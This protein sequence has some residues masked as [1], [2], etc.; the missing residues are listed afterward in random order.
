MG[1]SM[2]KREI[3][4][5]LKKAAS[6]FPITLLTG[7][8]QS[9]KTTLLKTLFPDHK[10][11]NLETPSTLQ[12]LQDDPKGFLET[13]P[14]EFIL[15]EAQKFPGFFSYLQ[16]HVDQQ[17]KAKHIL[18][19]GSQ[20]FLLSEQI[21]QTLAGRVAIL[22]LL[23]L[24][25]QELLSGKSKFKKFS[26]WD[27]LYNG[28]YPRP[29]Q[30]KLDH[31]LWYNSYIRTYLERDIRSLIGLKDFNKFQLFLKLCA[32][33]HG[34][35][36]NMNALANDCGVSQPTVN[37]WL[38]IL[39]TTYIVY[40]LPPYYRNFNKRIIKSPK[41]YFY[42]SALVCQLLGIESAEQLQ[43][44]SGRGAIFEGYVISEI[45]K[46]YFNRGLTAPVFFWRDQQGDEVD[47]IVE[48][49]EK[50]TAYEV[51]SSSTY[52]SD[53]TKN[54]DKIDKVSHGMVAKRI[55]IYTGKEQMQLNQTL[56]L[57]WQNIE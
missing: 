37:H 45:I 11:L 22:E 38:G 53:F 47:L 26:V 33:R 49:G 31:Q 2:F 52:T 4:Q 1:K 30:E 15:D 18:L 24:T 20:N 51:K 25:H 32:G 41:L 54:L 46:N 13:Q 50:I 12:A 16:E 27:F 14:G 23:P 7:P 6:S 9:G 5:Q 57:P 55:L 3:E 35:I 40:R 42:D 17:P 29:Y 48:T 44:H 56:I 43:Y 39:E 10:Y 21:S 34:Q 8:R 28:S 36:L 19:S